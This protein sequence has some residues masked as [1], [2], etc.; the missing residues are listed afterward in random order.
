M[1]PPRKRSQLKWPNS[2]KYLRSHGHL[3]LILRVPFLCQFKL[4]ENCTAAELD[5]FLF[6]LVVSGPCACLTVT[7]T[8]RQEN[9]NGTTGAFGTELPPGCLL[10]GQPGRTEVLLLLWS[11]NRSHTQRRILLEAF[12]LVITQS[13]GRTEGAAQISFERWALLRFLE[14][15]GWA[16]VVL[17][18]QQ[19]CKS[20]RW[21]LNLTAGNKWEL[22]ELDGRNSAISWVSLWKFQ[23]GKIQD[24]IRKCDAKLL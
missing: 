1:T 12:E 19:R 8:E 5:V 20:S 10:R 16:E 22:A 7:Q 23:R 4:I 11:R 2:A 3:I 13:G 9:A 18:K 6:W 15:S 17:A 14:D 24:T 21:V